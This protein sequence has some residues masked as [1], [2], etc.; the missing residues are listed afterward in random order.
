VARCP[1]FTDIREV[2]GRHRLAPGDYCILPSTFEPG[3]EGD[4]LLRIYTEQPIRS[5][6]QPLLAT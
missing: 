1:Q 6:C 5:R 4:F 3:D 2:T